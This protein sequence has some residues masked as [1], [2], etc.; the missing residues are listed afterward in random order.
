MKKI[1]LIGSLR[2]PIIPEIGQAIREL[3]FD[4]FDDWHAAGPHADDCWKEY[5]QARG[6]SYRYALSGFAAQHVYEFDLHHLNCSDI[7]VLVLPA[8]RSGHLELGFLAGQGKPT[9]IL[10]D[11]AEER[12]DVM[13]K[14]ATAVLPSRGWLTLRLQDEV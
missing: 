11:E 14:F 3:G 1:Y 2:N 12:W 4:V 9:F 6:H 13:Y 7:G 5:E 10:L 8:G